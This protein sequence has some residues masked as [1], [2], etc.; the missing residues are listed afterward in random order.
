MGYASI[1]QSQDIVRDDACAFRNAKDVKDHTIH[2]S[3]SINEIRIQ[4]IPIHRQ[5]NRSQELQ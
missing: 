4:K 2:G 3:T 5:P 1:A